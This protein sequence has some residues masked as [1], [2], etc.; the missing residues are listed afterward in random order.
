VSLRFAAADE[1]S[2]RSCRDVLHDRVLRDV[3]AAGR[4]GTEPAAV[5]RAIISGWSWLA[6]RSVDARTQL[7][8]ELRDT[9]AK[10]HTTARAW[11]PLAVAETDPDLI[12]AAVNGYLGSAPRSAEQR[13]QALDDIFEWF[14]RDLT[15]DRVGVFVALFA[16]REP[17]VNARLALLRGRLDDPERDRVLREFVYATDALTREFIAEWLGERVQPD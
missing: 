4:R 13:G 17:D 2:G 1:P 14:R 16:L 15:L 3:I 9:V 12:R 8:A 5:T 11:L 6:V 10:G 7:Q